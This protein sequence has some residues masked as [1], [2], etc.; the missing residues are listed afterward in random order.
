[1]K[2]YLLKLIDAD[3]FE[4]EKMMKSWQ[5]ISS[6]FPDEKFYKMKAGACRKKIEAA[7]KY[8]IK[9]TKILTEGKE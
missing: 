3:I 7:Q 4:N 9:L 8:K 2:K 5:E 1:M 6:H